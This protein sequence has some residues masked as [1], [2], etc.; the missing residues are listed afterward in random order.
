MARTATENVLQILVVFAPQIFTFKDINCLNN[1]SSLLPLTLYL[2]P[3][4]PRS[5][6]VVNPYFCS[7]M[8]VRCK[9]RP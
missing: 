2:N 1:T 4:S 9:P 6:L 5:T 3:P 8:S 7:S